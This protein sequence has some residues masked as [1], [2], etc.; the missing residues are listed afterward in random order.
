MRVS[1][2][3]QRLPQSRSKWSLDVSGFWAKTP[4]QRRET[5]RDGGLTLGQCFAWAARAAHEVPLVDGEFEF[6]AMNA[7]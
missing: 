4:E 7:E 2:S 6:I 3:L 1:G 5:F